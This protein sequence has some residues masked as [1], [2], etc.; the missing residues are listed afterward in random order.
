VAIGRN[1]HSDLD[2]LVAQSGDAPGPFTLDQGSA[3]ELQA[4]LFKKRDDLIER[5]DHDAN[6]V[7]SAQFIFRHDFASSKIWP[8]R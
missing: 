5:F 7:H 3:F 8:N 1:H 2:S 4:K 6:I